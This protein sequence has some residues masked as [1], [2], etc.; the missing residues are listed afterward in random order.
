[1][2]NEEFKSSWQLQEISKLFYEPNALFI[3][4]KAETSG[5]SLKYFGFY[6]QG[7]G[8]ISEAEVIMPFALTL[9]DEEVELL[10]RDHI[11][12]GVV[13]ETTRDA[14]IEGILTE[15]SIQFEKNYIPET[16]IFGRTRIYVPIFYS[17]QSAD[18]KEFQGT[19]SFEHLDGVEMSSE[20]VFFMTHVQDIEALK[21][22]FR[23]ALSSDEN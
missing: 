13:H 8:E 3:I 12:K 16:N 18:G 2:A 17:G 14:Q 20:G 5:R 22:T 21:Q 10:N 7:F 19:W 11:L 15:N 1:M 23:Q 9:S 6:R 4:E